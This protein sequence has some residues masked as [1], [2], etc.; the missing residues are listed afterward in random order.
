MKTTHIGEVRRLIRRHVKT[1]N[2]KFK[3]NLMIK[4][5]KLDEGF[6]MVAEAPQTIVY[7]PNEI[8]NIFN[9][10]LFFDQGGV[11]KISNLIE[12]LVAHETGHLMDY[13]KNSFL[14]YNE[15]Y[16][17]QMELNAWEIGE[18]YIREELRDEYESFRDFSLDSYR[19]SKKF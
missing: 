3:L 9:D 14:F 16:E 4:E 13:R 11:S 12:I 17:E 18:Q 19:R 8:K 2:E 1:I 5:E 15:G 6:Q 10:P 7:D